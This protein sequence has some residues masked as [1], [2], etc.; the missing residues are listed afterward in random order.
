MDH[1]HAFFNYSLANSLSSFENPSKQIFIDLNRA[2]IS[3]L[4]EYFKFL[5]II[6]SRH[7]ISLKK[8]QIPN[9]LLFQ[10]TPRN[11]IIEVM[12]FLD[13]E[14]KIL[15]QIK[16]Q[17]KEIKLKPL[18]LYECYLCSYF[19]KESSKLIFV[20]SINDSTLKIICF[21][22]MTGQRICET[23]INTPQN[24]LRSDYQLIGNREGLILWTYD[25][26]ILF[27]I[28]DEIKFIKEEIINEI[29]Y[30]KFSEKNQK[31]FFMAQKDL[32]IKAIEFPSMKV[33][34]TLLIFSIENSKFSYLEILDDPINLVMLAQ[35]ETIKFYS[36]SVIPLNFPKELKTQG[37]SPIK[38]FKF[39][40][41][42]EKGDDL[43]VL[44]SQTLELLPFSKKNSEMILL[45]GNICESLNGL[46][47]LETKDFIMAYEKNFTEIHL[48]LF[49]IKEPLLSQ[50]LSLN[51]SFPGLPFLGEE[52]FPKN[53]DFL[54]ILFLDKFG[55]V[56]KIPFNISN[57]QTELIKK[58]WEPEEVQFQ[59]LDIDLTRNYYVGLMELIEAWKSREKE[60]GFEQVF[61]IAENGKFFWDFK[62]RNEIKTVFLQLNLFSKNPGKINESSEEMYFDDCTKINAFAFSQKDQLLAISEFGTKFI[63]IIEI[64][65]SKNQIK[66]KN[67]LEFNYGQRFLNQHKEILSFSNPEMKKSQFLLFHCYNDVLMRKCLGLV[68]WDVNENQLIKKV[69]FLESSMMETFGFSEKMKILYCFFQNGKCL[70]FDFAKDEIYEEKTLFQGDSFWVI[71]FFI[72]GFSGITLCN[73]NLLRIYDLKSKNLMK[74]MY[75]SGEQFLF[76]EYKISQKNLVLLDLNENLHKITGFSIEEKLEK[77]MIKIANKKFGQLYFFDI[78]EEKDV[79]I[80]VRE[81][82]MIQ[83]FDVRNKKILFKYSAK[84]EG[85]IKAAYWLQFPSKIMI[86][87]DI[88]VKIIFLYCEWK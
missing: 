15:K 86:V 44:T 26:L 87:A 10:D 52:L 27:E 81:E 2:K 79:L 35:N 33:V 57:K 54:N 60:D 50:N 76:W 70:C 47:I 82:S 32:Y 64:N 69:E 19:I 16:K 18:S 37:K 85:N 7:F 11:K 39:C 40:K 68:I 5:C 36:S 28:G 9:H 14:K 43:I 17:E 74:I 6:R 3:R 72:E 71:G 31:K 83:I 88:Y 73:D 13:S 45:Q 1:L 53:P 78:Y 56:R 42:T 22:I 41:N 38:L 84:S 48:K 58:I 65:E 62:F 4:R 80:A 46:K 49:N 25:I 23:L 67:V 8:H 55:Y 12:K 59:D 61:E 20:S 29:I 30:L 51:Y 77:R 34:E 75:F 63:K 24:Q 66:L 21:N